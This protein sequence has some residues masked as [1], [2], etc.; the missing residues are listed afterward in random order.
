MGSALSCLKLVLTC[1]EEPTETPNKTINYQEMK[2]MLLDLTPMPEALWSS[3]SEVDLNNRTK[4]TKNK[5]DESRINN[6]RKET[7]KEATTKRDIMNETNIQAKKTGITKG[8]Q[9]KNYNY[10]PQDYTMTKFSLISLEKRLSAFEGDGT[11]KS[12]LF[13]SSSLISKG[14][15][16]HVNS[17]KFYTGKN[18]IELETAKCWEDEFLASIILNKDESVKEIKSHFGLDDLFGSLNQGNCPAQFSK[19]SEVLTSHLNRG[20]FRLFFQRVHNEDY[21]EGLLMRPEVLDRLLSMDSSRVCGSMDLNCDIDR[22][23]SR[24]D[25]VQI[26]KKSEYIESFRKIGS[27]PENF[28]KESSELNSQVSENPDNTSRVLPFVELSVLNCFKLFSFWFLI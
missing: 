24:L 25:D 4:S 3:E 27:F 21:P 12:G 14:E 15:T 18:L 10:D 5:T 6:E 16:F 11:I 22:V 26:H 1:F 28:S 20:N 2:E 13:L 17:P 9:D 19:E 23:F 8:P 7:K